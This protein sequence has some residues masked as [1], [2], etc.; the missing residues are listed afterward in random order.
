MKRVFTVL[1][2]I[3]FIAVVI[4]VGAMDSASIFLPT[5]IA[6]TG[7]GLYAFA[8]YVEDWF[9]WAERREGK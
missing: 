7:L 1:K 9:V 4:G 8:D 5:V 3:G 6:F 2:S